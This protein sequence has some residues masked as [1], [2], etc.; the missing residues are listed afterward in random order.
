[1]KKDDLQ[2]SQSQILNMD[3]SPVTAASRKRLFK[4]VG[5]FVLSILAFL[6]LVLGASA[7]Y[8]AYYKDKVYPG[9]YVGEYHFGDDTTDQI[10]KF[11]ENL[12][13][14]LAKEG[15]G[16]TATAGDK[17]I[18]FKIN[19]V[20]AGDPSLEI[21]KLDGVGLGKEALA[22]AR[23]GN[24]W[25]KLWQPLKLRFYPIHLF[26]PV[27]LEDQ[28]LR[29]VLDINLNKI[30]DTPRSANVV[31][32]GFPNTKIEIIPEHAGQFFDD[33]EII[34]QIQTDLSQLKFV[35]WDITA[36]YFK[37]DIL[38]ADVG[39]LSEQVASILNYGSI[40][41]NHIDPQTKFQRQWV[42]T[43]TQLGEWLQ[44]E[45]DDSHNLIFSLNE[46]SVKKYLEDLRH[47]VD[48]PTLDAKFSVMDGKV[49][50][51]QGSRIGLTLNIDKTYEGVA[52]VFK[53]RNYHPAATSRAVSLSVDLVE[54]NV[55]MADANNLG[56]EAI[57]GSG[58]STFKDSH[59]NRIKNIAHA[60][61]RLNGTLI[62]PGEEFSAN[63]YAGP[64]TSENGYLPEA[65]I[66]GDKITDEIGGGMCQ[67]GTTLFRMAMNSGMD[68]TQRRNHSLVVSYY[69]DPVNGNPGTDATLYEPSLDLKFKND[70]DNYL[71]LQTDIDY[72]KQQLTFTLWG[73]PDGRSGSYTH[74]LVSKWISAGE[75]Q[76]IVSDSLKPGVVSCQS[77]FRGAVASFMYTRVT[78]S[79][80]KIARE[81]ESYYR[82][83]PKICM[84]GATT[85]PVTTV[86]SAGVPDLVEPVQ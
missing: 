66:K 45:R 55:K 14:R 76:T 32:H 6:I 20:L 85:T 50:E 73:K 70:T 52:Q 27:Q 68:I 18:E 74:P 83:L 23:T 35:S 5:I 81:F 29:E 28:L 3:I 77:A 51:F 46:D 26:A 19:T 21:V 30:S 1:M 80:V 57:I 9:V 8:F 48:Y 38:E 4:L 65:V 10:N 34:W 12:N 44:V 49:K 47:L 86:D 36:D 43:A 62:K 22:V 33:A 40:T 42:I 15:L 17:K 11:I 41:L 24:W 13:D 63:K 67:I 71:L 69:A 39:A 84:V 78:T 72:D 25:Q 37:P 61:E 59:N 54:P 2:N 60:V 75:T 56:I 64:F 82:P 7:G 16:I 58:F 79:G 53:D 31:A